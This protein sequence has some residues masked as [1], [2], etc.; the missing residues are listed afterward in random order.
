MPIEEKGTGRLWDQGWAL[1][2]EGSPEN[3]HG[4]LPG[5]IRTI[6]GYAV[7]TDAGTEQESG[8]RERILYVVIL[9]LQQELLSFTAPVVRAGERGAKGQGM[10]CKQGKVHGGGK[11]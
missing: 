11:G 4:Y 1:G 5:S 8:G 6:Q 3:I 10:D 7:C 9:F 2:L